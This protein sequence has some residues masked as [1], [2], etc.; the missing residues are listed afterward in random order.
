VLKTEKK[1]KKKV[2]GSFDAIFP[3]ALTVVKVSTSIFASELR[4]LSAGAE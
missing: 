3:L 4:S 2:K 1:R